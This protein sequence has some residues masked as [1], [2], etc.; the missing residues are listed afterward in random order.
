MALSNT[1]R[2]RRRTSSTPLATTLPRLDLRS[3]AGRPRSSGGPQDIAHARILEVGESL[4]QSVEALHQQRTNEA[5]QEAVAKA[6]ARAAEELQAALRAQSHQ[7]HDDLQAAC[8]A[9]H[10]EEH[11][12]QL[13]LQAQWQEE[14]RAAVAQARTEEQEAALQR[15]TEHKA[16]EARE[17]LKAIGLAKMETRAGTWAE[18]EKKEA[19]EVSK[20]L[21]RAG[22]KAQEECKGAVASALDEAAARHDDERR[23]WE[24]K[25]AKTQAE[26][27]QALSRIKELE[28]LLEQEQHTRAEWQR[29][30]S[31]L[32]ADYRRT[33][34]EHLPNYDAS[35][36]W[37]L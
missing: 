32:L 4:K 17:R 2:S 29:K 22:V 15:L 31:D 37:L 6:E 13:Q 16:V 12:H 18:A 26:L 30:H 21:E 11:Q 35:S 7:H 27:D 14:M 28:T 9:V 3:T 5:V 19:F 8:A 20:A 24:A 23:Q 10:E 25:H 33:L 34:E 36:S 1:A